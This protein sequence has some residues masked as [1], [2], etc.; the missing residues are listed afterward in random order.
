[1]AVAAGGAHLVTAA[2]DPWFLHGEAAWSLIVELSLADASLYLEDRSGRGVNAVLVNLIDHKFSDS[3]PN[4][5]EGQ[6][7]FTVPGD[8]SKPNE[9]YF[10]HADEVLSLAEQQGL[11]VLLFPSYLGYA[12]GD[13]GWFQEMSALSPTEC[14]SY[15]T[16]VGQKYASHQNIIWM[17]GGDYLPPSGSAGQQCMKAIAA[18]IRASDPGKLASAHW[19]VES[20]SLASATFRPWVDLVGVYTY[21]PSLPPCR[22]ARALTPTRPT[23]LLETTYENEHAA[24]VSEVRRQQWWGALGCGSGEISGNLP[25]WRFASG[26]QAAL[27]SPLSGH[28][29]RLAAILGARPWYDLAPDDAL[30]S[31]GAGSGA[32]AVAAESTADGKLAVIY[33]PPEGAATLTIDLSRFAGPVTGTWVDPTA[34]FGVDAGAG[35]SGSHEF[36]RPGANAAGD[37]DWVLILTSG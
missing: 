10:D 33:D 16:F 8:F 4:N 30:V 18:G 13:E 11:A 7:P 5:A 19:A 37:F 32:G 26:W 17:W 15:G 27:G 36:V 24:P 34:T 23:F 12:G 20:N 21:N 35:L 29:Q 2:G 9:A 6:A 31:A 22:A 25:I 3:P 14:T 28:Q 1:V